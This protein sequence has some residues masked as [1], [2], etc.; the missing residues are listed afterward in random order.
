MIE[1]RYIHTQ[2]FRYL[3][4][5]VKLFNVVVES[6]I[7]PKKILACYLGPLDANFIF[8]CSYVEARSNRPTT[9]VVQY[10]QTH[11]CK[12]QL[13]DIIHYNDQRGF[14]NLSSSMICL[15]FTV[16]FGSV[17]IMTLHTSAKYDL[18]DARKGR[19]LKMSRRHKQATTTVASK[20]IIQTRIISIVSR[21][22]SRTTGTSETY[23]FPQ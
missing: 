17:A 13:Q 14:S 15:G 6:L 4:E 21:D 22:Y 7:R 8:I 3:R 9:Y 2:W 19:A 5:D 16:V 18:C 20:S 12:V 11:H 1:V 10:L 23:F